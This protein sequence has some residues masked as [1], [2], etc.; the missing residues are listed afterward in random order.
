M[1]E[2]KFRGRDNNGVWYYGYI[3]KYSFNGYTKE[4]IKFFGESVSIVKEET[5]GQYTGLKDKNGNEI[6]EGD[7]LGDFIGLGVVKYNECTAGF[8][9][10]ILGKINE[11]TFGEI[12][13]NNYVLEV[14]GNIYENPDI[15]DI[16]K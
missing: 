6:Y 9:I 4:S 15:L 8:V 11:I 12:N 7:I 1:R 3:N 16:I 2:I 13:Y 5:V 14:I 10:D